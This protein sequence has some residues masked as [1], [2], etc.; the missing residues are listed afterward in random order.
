MFKYIFLFSLFSAQFVSSY[1]QNTAKI[2]GIIK[3]NNG[4]AVEFASVFLSN[5]QD[6]AKLIKGV[7]TDSLG[8]FSISNLASG[9]YILKVSMIG[10]LSVKR[11]LSISYNSEKVVLPTI[12]LTSD[13]T[14]LSQVNVTA[15]KKMIT[16]TTQGFIINAQDNIAQ[17]A[18]SAT[19][20]LRNTP[21]VVVDAE[22]GITVRGKAPMIL[23]NG[24][25]SSLANT[26]RI[27]ASSIETIEIINNP[28]AQYD[29]DAEG[30][31]INI[32]LKKNKERGTNGA[33]GIGAGYGA[34]GR[35]NSSLLLGHQTE[36]WNIGAAYDNRFAE[37]VRIA[38]ASRTNFDLPDEYYLLQNR[39]DNRLEN[40]QNLKFN[41]DFNPNKKNSFG[42]E[43]LGNS[44]G[45][46]NQETLRSTLKRKN[47]AFNNANTRHSAELSNEKALEFAFD[48][49]RKF[50]N[51][52]QKLS[53]N[54]SSA[55]NKEQENTDITTQA[56]NADDSKLGNVFLQRTNNYQNTNVN[57]FKIDYA[58][59]YGKN[60]TLEMGYKAI[61][62]SVDADFQNKYFQNND[63]VVNPAASNIF[64]FRE[65]IHAAY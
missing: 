34:K 12:I 35:F 61:T 6:S 23:I 9:N 33:V 50:E 3:E 20:L 40:T 8:Q 54:V 14:I 7:T 15:Q 42:L 32:T 63:Y 1:A 18:G 19:D 43:I 52:R 25:N 56:L 13:A 2:S 10:Y 58:Q 28:S 48:Y 47:Q 59:P 21:T 30:G 49:K 16:K 27:P 36:K 62:R 45:Q 53:I 31:I 24:R 60:A 26:D 46:N 29:A 22:G 41:V 55:F 44:E 17:A 11:T 38:T 57:N 4:A 37:R 64:V 39:H 51:K 5:A 65:Q